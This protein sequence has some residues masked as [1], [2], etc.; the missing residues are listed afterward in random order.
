MEFFRDIFTFKRHYELKESN[1]NNN[2]LGDRI[3]KEDRQE[4]DIKNRINKGRATIAMLN[5]ILWDRNIIKEIKLQIYNSIVRSTF[6][7]GAKS[8]KLN[9]N[10]N[11]KINVLEMDFLRRSARHN[12]NNNNNNNNNPLLANNTCVINFW[13]RQ[14]LHSYST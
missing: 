13:H 10:F 5:S 4:S 7:Y 14:C 8:W 6:T 12:N 3:D 9:K 1:N 11:I 2:N